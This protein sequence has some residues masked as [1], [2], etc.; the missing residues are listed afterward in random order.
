[1]GRFIDLTGKQFGRLTVIKSTNKRS[2]SGHIVWL[3]ECACGKVVET[4]GVNLT[5]SLSN[6]CGCLNRE[7]INKKITKH[8]KWGS[9]EYKSWDSMIQRC[10]NPKNPRY[11][12]YGGRGIQVCNRWLIFSNFFHDMGARPSKMTLDRIDV[13]GNY[14]PDNCQWAT[15]SQ[16]A[17]NKRTSK[18]LTLRPY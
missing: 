13:N 7:K 6:S 17:T 2:Y 3:C 12:D 8:N 15:Y 11:K 1:M 9:P 16:Q 18:V 10:S 4:R 14:E 5:R